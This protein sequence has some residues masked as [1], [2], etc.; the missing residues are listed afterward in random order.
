MATTY[1]QTPISFL[2]QLLT[3]AGVIASG[4]TLTTY[5]A[6][7]TSTLQTTYANAGGSVANPNPMTL[8]SAGRP[9]G[10]SAAFTNFWLPS[11]VQV[12]LYFQDTLG[13]TWTI[14]GI[15]GIN[16]PSAPGS[17]ATNL[18]NPA[19]GFGVDLVANGV[20]SYD[21]FADL[22][23]ANVPSLAAGQTLVVAI[24]GATSITDG[25]GGLFYWNATSTAADDGKNTIE[26]NAAPATGRYLRLQL[27]A[28]SGSGTLTGTGFSGS[29]PTFT[30]VYK[31]QN[32]VV[33]L[34]ITG[35]T[36]T[37]NANTFTMTG[38]L[39]GAGGLSP[40]TVGVTLPCLVEDNGATQ[41]GWVT[42]NTAGTLTFGLGSTPNFS[43]FTTSGTKGIPSVGI[44]VTFPQV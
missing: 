6:G 39:S 27:G 12:D 15:A 9:A 29:A 16:D 33:S 30:Y 43:G 40:L 8:S 22:R 31:Q 32:G 36:G 20:K 35:N 25:L 34:I 44:T 38:L 24:E 5:L 28:G 10:S 21:V 14:Y 17:I 1:Y 19:T 26:P 42:I 18:A 3:N 7:S 41:A 11:G 13:E 37:S 4:A 2:V 23:A